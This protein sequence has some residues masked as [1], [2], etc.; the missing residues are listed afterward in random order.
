MRPAKLLPLIVFILGILAQG[1][2]VAAA[3]PAFPVPDEELPPLLETTPPRPYEVLTPLGAGK[4]DLLEAR[5]Q[6]RREGAKA[7]A[8]AVLLLGCESGG[9]GRDGLTFYRKD[10]YCRGLAIRYTQP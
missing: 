10:A 7:Q 8:E 9:M 3:P 1:P 6:L 4:K 2:A 5:L